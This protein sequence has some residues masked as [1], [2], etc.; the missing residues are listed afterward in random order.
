MVNEARISARCISLIDQMLRE[1]RNILCWLEENEKNSSVIQYD[2]AR[3]EYALGERETPPA[4][5][6]IYTKGEF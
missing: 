4:S 2:I 1:K 6:R 5:K 3:M